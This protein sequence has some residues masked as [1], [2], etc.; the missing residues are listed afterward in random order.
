[1]TPYYITS[2]GTST[3]TGVTIWTNWTRLETC[4]TTTATAWPT[5]WIETTASITNAATT[6]VVWNGRLQP[7]APSREQVHRG[8]FRL[9]TLEEAI[10]ANRARE[11]RL[12]QLLAR[13]RAAQA[14]AAKARAQLLLRENL[15]DQQ[16]A[17][18]ADKRFFTLTKIDSATGERRHYRIHTGRAGNVEQVDENGQRLARYCIHPK[19]SCPDEDTML[20][21]KLML[22]TCEPEFLR[23]ANRS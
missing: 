5:S 23:V 4:A 22:E 10:A 3:D 21:Q 15:T 16:K 8:G 2:R 13:T 9:P 14:E 6:W 7:A 18:L 11:E 17:E 19:I 12:D 20:A 1:M